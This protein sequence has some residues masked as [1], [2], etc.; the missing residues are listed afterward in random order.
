M[1]AYDFHNSVTVTDDLSTSADA[2]TRLYEDALYESGHGGYSGTIA[3][4]PGFH[5]FP[6]NAGA[7]AEKLRDALERCENYGDEREAATAKGEVMN[8][9]QHPSDFNFILE[10]YRDKWAPAICVRVN[11]EYHFFGYASS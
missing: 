1:G 8:M 5:E 2:F 10:L 9:L 7:T 4:K 6:V 3:E 11:D